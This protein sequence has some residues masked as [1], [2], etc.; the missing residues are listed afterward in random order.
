MFRVLASS[1]QKK[2]IP[3]DY[4]QAYVEYKRN[5]PVDVVSEAQATQSLINAGVPEEIAYNQLSCVDDINY[6]MELKE[7][8]KQD[9]LDMF[10]P[11]EEEDDGAG[12]EP[13]N[14]DEDES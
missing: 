3:F 11:D 5:F 4:L 1:F 13:V 10:Q 6:L 14:G 7:Q 12:E 9:A 8:K 2:G